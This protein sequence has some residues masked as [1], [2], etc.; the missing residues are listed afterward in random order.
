MWRRSGPGCSASPGPD[1]SGPDPPRQARGNPRDAGRP[2]NAWAGAII[3]RALGPRIPAVS[4]V[5]CNYNGA[6]YLEECL[7]SVLAQRPD[8]VLVVDDGSTDGSVAFLHARFPSLEVLELGA[9]RGPCAAR[10]A[11]MRA[12]RNRWVLA[13]D[14]DAV[15]EPGVLAKL[16]AALEARPEHTV[17]QARSVLYR[18]P[19]RVHYDGGGFH[20]LGLI[21]L[22]NFYTPL[23]EAEGSG[24]VEA[25][26]LIGICALL[27]RDLVLSAG[28]YDEDLFY[29]AEDLDLSLRLR[30]QGQRLL[31]VEDALVRHRGGTAGLSFRGGGYPRRRVFLQARNRWWIL[32]KCYSVRSL[33]VALPGLV[34]YEGV[35]LVFALAQRGLG[36]HLSGK[37][38]CLCSWRKIARSRSGVQALRVVPDR[39]LLVG[40]PLVL[41][42]S[43]VSS[44][45]ARMAARL[46]D[47]LLRAWWRVVRP[48]AG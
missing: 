37:W 23:E 19:T 11:G 16:S 40:G 9:N 4:A 7:L 14:N 45:P 34:L 28:G 41:S 2:G 5:V 36:A 30:I 26:A 8:E 25:D 44:A 12:A 21:A 17:A 29:L 31:S 6:S 33:L 32:G 20:Y 27:D 43:L 48:L 42:P 3:P 13:V 35:W 18:E 10:N 22:R 24:V 38:A 47:L 15:L 39:E 46:L 1:P